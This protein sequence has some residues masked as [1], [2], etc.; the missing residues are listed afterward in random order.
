MA[1]YSNQ[2]SSIYSG[3]A[4]YGMLQS[5]KDG[6]LGVMATLVTGGP[7][8]MESNALTIPNAPQSSIYSRPKPLPKQHWKASIKVDA[9]IT[10]AQ[11]LALKREIRKRGGVLHLADWNWYGHYT[12]PYMSALGVQYI[13][14]VRVAVIS[15]TPLKSGTGSAGPLRSFQDGSLGHIDPG[16]LRAYQDGSLGSL[17][18]FEDGSLG[19]MSGGPM[20]A[21]QDGSLG[22]LG[23]PLFETSKGVQQVEEPRSVGGGMGEYY[24]ATG[25]YFSGMAGCSSCSGLGQSQAA[26]ATVPVLNLSDPQV[27]VE[28]KTAML[29]APWMIVNMQQAADQIQADSLDPNWTP[30]T[31]QIAEAWMQGYGPWMVA[32][33]QGSAQSATAE[34]YA[35]AAQQGFVP[36]EQIPN[37][38]GVQAIFSVLE[39]IFLG[40]D[41]QGKNAVMTPEQFPNLVAFIGAVRANSGQGEVA[42]TKRPFFAQASAMQLGLG[43]VV[44]GSLLYLAFGTKRKRK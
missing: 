29:V 25:E 28:L 10:P 1:Y 27:M 14:G 8:K 24:A 39:M 15:Q 16:K 4:G 35:V 6:S 11:R 7:A 23:F 21:Y 12:Y 5:Y 9:G 37:V 30:F 17:Q 33:L 43:A 19:S 42:F 41:G 40:E 44:L 36:P 22:S 32:T 18:A 26:S 13:G 34:E 31:T 3:A 2:G 38:L 20:M